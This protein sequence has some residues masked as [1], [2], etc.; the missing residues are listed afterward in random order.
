MPIVSSFVRVNSMSLVTARDIVISKTTLHIHS[1]LANERKREIERSALEKKEKKMCL[2][3][4][5]R[6]DICDSTSDWNVSHQIC[7]RVA[8]VIC[9]FD[10]LFP[11]LFSLHSV[12]QLMR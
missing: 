9:F 7:L 4:N 2:M 11:S 8:C 1:M 5:G 10:F 12:S 3:S 6:R